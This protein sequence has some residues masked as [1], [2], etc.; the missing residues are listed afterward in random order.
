VFVPSKAN[1][2]GFLTAFVTCR[3]LD[4]SYRLKEFLFS[5]KIKKPQTAVISCTVC[6]KL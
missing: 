3:A 6:G 5:S 4:R 2:T 1:S